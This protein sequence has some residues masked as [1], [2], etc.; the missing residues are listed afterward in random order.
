[1]FCF[2]IKESF[3]TP[4]RSIKEKVCTS[5]LIELLVGDASPL[6]ERLVNEG[7]IN[8]E[9]STEYFNGY[10][11][12]AIVFEGE[13]SDPK[14]VAEE[15]KAEISRLKEDGVDK[16]LFS[17]VRRGMYGAAIKQ[18]NSVE[19]IAMQMIDCAVT[20]CE[21]FDELKYLKALTAED[22]YRRLLQLDP[23][24]STLSVINP[25]EVL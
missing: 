23:E 10:G 21:L 18:F 12:S 2:G 7:L 1:M 15:I 4:E 8:D 24:N 22:V 13:S 19:N 9:F 14:R 16:K 5:M 6:Y 20:G 11:Y 17:A 25:L 3:P